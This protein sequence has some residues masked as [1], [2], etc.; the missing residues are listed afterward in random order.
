MKSLFRFFLSKQACSNIIQGH[1]LDF[2]NVFK[3]S[4]VTV[5]HPHV[6]RASFSRKNSVPVS[7]GS[8]V[9]GFN[10]VCTHRIT[11]RQNVQKQTKFLC[12]VC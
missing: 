10:V 4:G 5:A 8:P 11:W 1:I 6:P 7:F 9:T 2:K 12:K 3:H